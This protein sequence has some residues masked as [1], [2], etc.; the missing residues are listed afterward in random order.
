MGRLKSAAIRH[1]WPAAWLPYYSELLCLRQAESAR[2]LLKLLWQRLWASIHCFWLVIGS[3]F[4]WGD[5]E[6]MGLQDCSGILC[7]CRPWGTCLGCSQRVLEAGA[8]P[9]IPTR[10]CHFY[11]SSQAREVRHLLVSRGYASL[12]L[13]AIP[14]SGTHAVRD[15]LW[16][17]SIV[18]T[19]VHYNPTGA[20]C[21]ALG[22][23]GPLLSAF[24]WSAA[25]TAPRGRPGTHKKKTRKYF[26]CLLFHFGPLAVNRLGQWGVRSS[27]PENSF[28]L[29]S[30]LLSAAPA[31]AE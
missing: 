5:E 2:L 7:F 10:R 24:G 12:G 8:R 21:W 19:A 17:F 14:A 3:V 27:R 15:A 13:Q 29:F 25:P 18:P 1:Y 26:R 31:R 4:S 6:N 30:P 11:N 28:H 9:F 20:V 22:T 23:D 16:I